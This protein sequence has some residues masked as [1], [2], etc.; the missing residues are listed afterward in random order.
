MIYIIIL[1]LMATMSFV[2]KTNNWQKA[3]AVEL[4]PSYFGVIDWGYIIYLFMKLYRDRNTTTSALKEITI[5][6][7]TDILTL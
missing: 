3:I 4:N 2:S 6:L 1:R 7:Q 5:Q